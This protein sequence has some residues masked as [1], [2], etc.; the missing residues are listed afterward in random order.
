MAK[1]V[2]TEKPSAHA[3]QQP[4][5]YPLKREFVEPDWRRFPGWKDVSAADWESALWQRR[6]SVK[7]IKELK[8]VFGELLPEDCAEEIALDQKR[9]ATMSI[10]VPPQM[11]NAMDP[12][13]FR[14]DPVRRY[15]LPMISDRHAEWP[16]HPMASR[17]SLHDTEM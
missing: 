1:I 15:F 17:D 8:E 14:N 4:F 9:L 3:A 2:R 12:A 16:N 7:N 11:I 5:E 10:L 6:H 13:N